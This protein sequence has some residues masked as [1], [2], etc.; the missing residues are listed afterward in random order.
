M[1]R[2]EAMSAS[3]SM[4]GGEEVAQIEIEAEDGSGIGAEETWRGYRASAKWYSGRM[5]HGPT[6]VSTRAGH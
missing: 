4:S 6:G 3:K 2:V 1:R 5:H